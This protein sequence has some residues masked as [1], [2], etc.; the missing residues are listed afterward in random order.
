MA[1]IAFL[2][3]RPF[4]AE[5]E[6]IEACNLSCSYC[7]VKPFRGFNPSFEELEYLFLKTKREVEPFDVVLDF[8]SCV[9]CFQKGGSKH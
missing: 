1:V 4:R 3:T 9:E 5:F 8:R 7:Y 2:P 6:L